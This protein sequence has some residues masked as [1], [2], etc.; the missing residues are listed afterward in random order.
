MCK[1]IFCTIHGYTQWEQSLIEIINTSEFQRLKHIRQLAAVHHV[2]PCA[3]HTRFEHSL[4]VGYLAEKYAN[5]LISNQPHLQC[6][7]FI[8]KLAGLCHD[9]GHGPL[10]HTFDRFMENKKEKMHVHE[11][12]SVI[13]LKYIVSKY[14]INIDE[15][16]V[17]DACELIHP[18]KHNLPQYMYQIIANN[19]D[20]IDVDKLDYLKRDSIYTG[21]NY[22]IDIIRFFQYARVINNIL[23]Y[24]LKNMQYTIN[25]VLMIRHQ[26]HA[27]VYQ[28]KV[29][30]AF[31]NMYIDIMNFIQNAIYFD[32]NIN[33]F[34]ELND[35]IFSNAFIKLAYLEGK[36]SQKNAQEA[37]KLLERINNRDIYHCTDEFRIKYEVIS[38]IPSILKDST[39]IILD[40]VNI[41]YKKNPLFCINFYTNDN[42]TITLNKQKVSRVFTMDT[43][44]CLLR[45]YSKN[46]LTLNIK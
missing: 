28:H 37:S 46:K 40:I 7:P 15:S 41:G 20:G 26:L 30:R 18:E 12:R 36:I 23:C 2:F 19:I 17:N 4:G 44:D 16:I 13:I 1:T 27:Q 6:N 8:L 38:K 10:S 21:L 42:D 32:G 31:E 45:L 29:V 9:L 39:D 3:V 14:K 5:T 35:N 24:S 11:L 33:K 22:N 43:K 34:M 25:H